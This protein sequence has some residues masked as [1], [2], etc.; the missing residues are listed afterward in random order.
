MK[1]NQGV[2]KPNWMLTSLFFKNKKPCAYWCVSLSLSESF[3]RLDFLSL[4]LVSKFIS[5][6]KYIPFLSVFGYQGEVRIEDLLRVFLLNMNSRQHC[7]VVLPCRFLDRF[8]CI[9]FGS[10]F[11]EGFDIIDARLYKL[12]SGTYAAHQEVDRQITN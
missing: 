6:R 3:I 12:R 10:V 9:P 5:A 11:Y 2:V 8:V 1:Q 4:F 7:L